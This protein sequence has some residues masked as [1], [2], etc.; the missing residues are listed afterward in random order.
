MKAHPPKPLPLR[1]NSGEP[2]QTDTASML[3]LADPNRPEKEI[4]GIEE[5]L[6]RQEIQ[7]Y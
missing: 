5:Q 1:N 7:Q 3:L 4:P 6:Y 2:A